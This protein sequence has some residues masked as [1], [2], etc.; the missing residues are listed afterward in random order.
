MVGAALRQHYGFTEH[1]VEFFTEHA[2]ADVEHSDRTLELVIRH[3]QTPELRRC[4]KEAV[5]EM[6]ERTIEWSVAVG[7]L[8]LAGSAGVMASP[9]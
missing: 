6:T 8:C 7:E 9:A 4:V 5:R 2:D 3:A 1:D